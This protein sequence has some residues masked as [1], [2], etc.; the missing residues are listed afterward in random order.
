MRACV[1]G[2][3][4]L[5][6]LVLILSIAC[7]DDPP[8]LPPQPSP[9]SPPLLLRERAQPGQRLE[10]AEV[11][12]IE[13][14]MPLDAGLELVQDIELVK[15]IEREIV[16]ISP[17][18]EI[19]KYRKHFKRFR[20]E[21]SLRLGDGPVQRDALVHPLEGRRVEYLWRD[22]RG[23]EARLTEGTLEGMD[24]P[25]T[26][27]SRRHPF[28][29]ERPVVSGDTWEATELPF[30]LPDVE[31]RRV[32]LVLAAVERTPEQTVARVELKAQLGEQGQLVGFYTFHVEGGRFLKIQLS[33][34]LE[35]PE[36]GALS[37]TS[38]RAFGGI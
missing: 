26:W 32:T 3:L 24:P 16:Q 8:E 10:I 14:R 29:P 36:L 9:E 19:A 4:A 25:S 5:T 13:R 27:K 21:S 1:R 35:S 15:H 31:A 2:G 30:A 34:Q 23:W 11:T 6:F 12:T 28:L 20:Q 33:A 7:R 37:I 17:D 38:Y 22:D 18:G